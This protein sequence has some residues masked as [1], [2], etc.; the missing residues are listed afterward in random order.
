MALETGSLNLFG[1]D[2][3]RAWS[4]FSAGWADAVH[5]PPLAWLKPDP[6]VRLLRPDG[7]VEWRRGASSAPAPAGSDAAPVAVLLPDDI[8][9]YR[10]L[11][12]PDLLPDDLAKAAALEAELNSPFPQDELAWGMRA[13]IIESG[14]RKLRIALASRKHVGAYLES[15]GIDG[16][17]VEIWAGEGDAGGG[18]VVLSGYCELRR[19]RL[20]RR[21]RLGI[22]AALS[23]LAALLLVLAAAPWYVQ[24]ARV[25]DAQ[26]RHASLEAAV[27]PV[28]AD[29]EALLRS[30]AQLTAIGQHL[31]TEADALTVLARLT[32][33][34]PDNA[35]LTRLEINGAQVRFAGIASNA[36]QLVESLGGQD[37]FSDVRTPTAISRTADGRESFTVELSLRAGGAAQP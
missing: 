32:A 37:I 35:H 12:L 3:S 17:N 1:L 21:R 34:L 22:I 18:P 27:A 7:T 13:S 26:A 9:L 5:W 16:G 29:R 24:R 20:F 14:K 31:R 8:V 28:V 6:A 15:R 2:L 4:A 23:M 19:E 36:A 11:L 10:E 33:V 30:S 25:F